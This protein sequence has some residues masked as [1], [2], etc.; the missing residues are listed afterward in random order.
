MEALASVIALLAL[1]I[2]YRQWKNDSIRLKHELYDRRLK[3]YKDLRRLLNEVAGADYETVMVIFDAYT[4]SHFLFD[5][6]IPEYLETVWDKANKVASLNTQMQGGYDMSNPL[7]AAEYK[8]YEDAHVELI[9]WFHDQYD[10]A[11]NKFRK[12]LAIK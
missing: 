5:D 4:E 7:I 3:V 10:E 6:D 1:Y 9:V 12:Y 2:A 8:G 11:K